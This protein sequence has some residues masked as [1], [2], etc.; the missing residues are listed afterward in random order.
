MLRLNRSRLV[1]ALVVLGCVLSIVTVATATN[2]YTIDWWTVDGGGATGIESSDGRFT[3]SGSIG[4]PDAGTVS[5]DTYTVDGGFWNGGTTP[6][7]DVYL[8]AIIK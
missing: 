7:Y 1:I 8:P 2:Q 4:Q 5:N 3:L 6:T